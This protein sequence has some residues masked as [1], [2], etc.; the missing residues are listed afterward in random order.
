MVSSGD[1]T[2]KERRCTDI[3]HGDNAPHPA[4]VKSV[5][6]GGHICPGIDCFCSVW[7]TSGNAPFLLAAN[8]IRLV[9][10]VIALIWQVSAIPLGSCSVSSW[11][12]RG[13]SVVVKRVSVAQSCLVFDLDFYRAIAS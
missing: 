5:Q 3:T 7:T 9:S 11:G 12:S 8:R 6:L 1:E 4:Q 10:D 13:P 2:V